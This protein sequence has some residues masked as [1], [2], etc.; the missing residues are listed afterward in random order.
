MGLFLCYN[1]TTKHGGKHMAYNKHTWVTQ[2]LVTPEKLN[3]IEIGVAENQGN[4]SSYQMISVDN[5]SIF[6]LNK[7]N[8]V[9][10]NDYNTVVMTDNDVFLHSDFISVVPDTKISFSIYAKHI[11]GLNNVLGTYIVLQFYTSEKKYISQK[12]TDPIVNNDWGIEK[13]E[14]ITVP[15]NAAY[16]LVKFS[17]RVYGEMSNIIKANRPMLNVGT[18]V[19]PYSNDENNLIKNP[20]FK[21]G[22]SGWFQKVNPNVKPNVFSTFL[23]VEPEINNYRIETSSAVTG[24]LPDGLGA[25]SLAGSF[26]A[27]RGS[28]VNGIGGITQSLEAQGKI[29]QRTFSYEWS[30][31]QMVNGVYGSFDNSGVWHSIYGDPVVGGV[32]YSPQDDNFYALDLNGKTIKTVGYVTAPAGANN[33]EQTIKLKEGGVIDYD[34]SDSDVSADYVATVNNHLSNINKPAIQMIVTDTHGTSTRTML[35]NFNKIFTGYQFNDL[36]DDGTLTPNPKTN[37]VTKEDARITHSSDNY[38]LTIARKYT[39]D[40]SRNIKLI[41]DKF[42]IK[43]DLYSNLGDVEDGV[44]YNVYEERISYNEASSVMKDQGFKFIDGNHDEQIYYPESRM[45]NKDNVGVVYPTSEH[46]F[47]RRVDLDRYKES[48]N[49][50]SLYFSVKDDT[51]K[52]KYIYLD[53]FEGG[54]L[55][56]KKGSTPDYGVNV[57]QSKLSAKQIKWLISELQNLPEDWF[58]VINSH[59]VPDPSLIGEIPTGSNKDSWWKT[60]VN[61][62]ILAGIL[63][64]FQ[65]GGKYKGKSNIVGL[66]AYDYSAYNVSVDVDFSDK[67]A[68]RVV[69]WN[70]GHHHGYG[71]KSIAENGYFNII[72]HRNLLDASWSYIGNPS[73]SQFSTQIIDTENRTVTNVRFAPTSNRDADFTLNF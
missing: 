39:N 59:N 15:S 27:V 52:I 63:I 38:Y 33:K 73:G 13:I 6:D 41:S 4:G 18:T 30:D 57:G 19:L 46:G 29:Y 20:S 70:Y 64:A 11:N 31:W 24:T 21:Q 14:N 25:G 44:N 12:T 51:H 68:N 8:Y 28:S 26:L 71:H 22:L 3:N 72:Q 58:V 42:N 7:V 67:P 43:P 9:G 50:D 65:T 56:N 47:Y 66:G 61:P 54:R 40:S 17:T 10:D 16:V 55:K 69:V 60:N 1:K 32:V 5:N 49:E 23:E 48:Y 36:I 35:K 62:D 34:M 2:E 37:Y 53:T 45:I